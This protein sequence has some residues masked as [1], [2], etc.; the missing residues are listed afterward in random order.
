MIREGTQICIEHDDR[1]ILE[2]IV[3]AHRK[4][5]LV[6]A[7]EAHKTPNFGGICFKFDEPISDKWMRDALERRHLTEDERGMRMR[8]NATAAADAVMSSAAD[9][10]GLRPPSTVMELE[11]GRQPGTREVSA[12]LKVQVRTDRSQKALRKT[13]NRATA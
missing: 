7:S 9:E 2:R 4:F 3:A 10:A 5:G 6:D 8:E 1:A 12:P 13:S 11:E